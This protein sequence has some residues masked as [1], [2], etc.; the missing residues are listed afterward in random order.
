MRPF[1]RARPALLAGAAAVLL[2]LVLAPDVAAAAADDALLQRGRKLFN[3]ATAPACSVCHTLADA[4]AEGAVG[5]VLDEIKPDA[6]RVAKAISNGLGAMPSL[7]SQLAEADIAALAAY[8]A[9]A[10]GAAK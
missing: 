9:A 6:A 5:P 8:V 10:T 2:S 1:G 3:Q 4:R 7:R